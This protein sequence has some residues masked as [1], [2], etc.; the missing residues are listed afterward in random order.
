[1]ST[2]VSNDYRADFKRV[3]DRARAMQQEQEACERTGGHYFFGT[4][5]SKILYPEWEY[6]NGV[7]GLIFDGTLPP[8]AAYSGPWFCSRCRRCASQEEAAAYRA[9]FGEIRM[10][11]DS[12]LWC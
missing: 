12:K 8:E 11:W 1:M 4:G 2:V 7:I 3:A 10:Y 5:P 9:R 6:P